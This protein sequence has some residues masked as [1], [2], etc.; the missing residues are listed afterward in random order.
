MA[1]TLFTPVM[2]DS[3]VIVF[4]NNSDRL[5]KQED[6]KSQNTWGTVELGDLHVEPIGE[7][8]LPCV[9]DKARH[10]FNIGDEVTDEQLMETMSRNG[11][12]LVVMVRQGGSR[13]GLLLRNCG[14]PSLRARARLAPCGL[15]DDYFKARKLDK[16]AALINQ[17]L[18]EHPKRKSVFLESDKKLSGLH[19]NS[20]VPMEYVDMSKADTQIL[21]RDYPEWKLITSEMSHASA[22]TMYALN[23]KEL[24]DSFNLLCRRTGIDFEGDPYLIT[25]TSDIADN[26]SDI[27]AYIKCER[28]GTIIPLGSP[29][30]VPHIRNA[31]DNMRRYKENL[32]SLANVYR[33]SMETF[34]RLSTITLNYPVDV[35]MWAGK[36]L[37]FTQT[38]NGIKSLTP[39]FLAAVDDYTDHMGIVNTALDIY[40]AL[41]NVQ[42]DVETIEK[43]IPNQAT[44]IRALNFDW[45]GWDRPF[46]F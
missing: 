25:S 22:H 21:D 40:L 34:E 36:A 31:A 44:I 6:R 29:Q 14:L 41:F 5:R 4:D 20:Y 1:T 38:V 26:G 11:T 37:G 3:E 35:M 28:T 8:T 18:M 17:G 15:L 7:G 10:D 30:V 46:S 16:A 42:N 13:K 12:G 43:L 9:L 33:D 32:G 27:R 23:S 2:G 39:A 19:G 45:A 24:L